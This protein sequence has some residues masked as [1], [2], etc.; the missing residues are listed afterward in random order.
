MDG[1]A[2]GAGRRGTGN[3]AVINQRNGPRRPRDGSRRNDASGGGGV[4][5][6]N[7]TATT[8]LPRPTS[9]LPLV[10]VIEAPPRAAPIAC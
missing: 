8:P 5:G 3:G 1:G 6:P 9:D 4:V 7:Q 10:E 2:S